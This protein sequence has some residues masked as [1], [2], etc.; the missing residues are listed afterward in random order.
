[1]GADV[2]VFVAGGSLTITDFTAEDMVD[3]TAFFTDLT[4]LVDDFNDDG[5]INQSLGDFTDNQAMQGS[6]TLIGLD[7]QILTVDTT[8]LL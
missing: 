3:L 7:D 8:G 2:F 6:I 4:E 1:M 5:L